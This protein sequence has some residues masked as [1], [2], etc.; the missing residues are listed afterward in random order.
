L[1]P[2]VSDRPLLPQSPSTPACTRARHW[3]SRPARPDKATLGR[4]LCRCLRA[5]F[6]AA[7]PSHARTRAARFCYCSR[8]A[9][10]HCRDPAPMLPRT[11]HMWT[12]PPPLTSV[13]SKSLPLPASPA[14]LA[15]RV[16]RAIGARHTRPCT[17]H[18]PTLH[19]F[20]GA[21]TFLSPPL[22]L[23]RAPATPL[24]TAW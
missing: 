6:C 13:V 18:R 3:D 20:R 8:P 19:C 22:H 21:R 10:G 4:P 1:D 24:S 17:L 7:L 12:R 11:S 15:C 14:R 23:V 5:T 9:L 2:P 16:L